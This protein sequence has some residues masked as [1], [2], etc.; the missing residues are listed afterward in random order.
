MRRIFSRSS[1]L[2]PDVKPSRLE[3][4]K[5]LVQS[6]LDHLQG[7]RVGLAVFSGTAFL[8][9]P[10]SADYEVL[11]EFLPNLGPDFLPEGGTNYRQLLETSIDAFGSSGAADR[12]LVILSDGE[13]NADDDWRDEIPKLKSP[14]NPSDRPGRGHGGRRNDS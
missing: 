5:L 2:T 1:M 9:S 8:Q 11:R 10:L 4:S 14:R 6:L 13:A 3:R 12:F 7:E